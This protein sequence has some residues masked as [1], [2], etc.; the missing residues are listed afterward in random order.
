M[1]T[2]SNQK[3][4]FTSFSCSV[5]LDRS[6]YMLWES[7]VLRMI[8]GDKMYGYISGTSKCPGEFI[9]EEGKQKENSAYEEWVA[10]DQKLL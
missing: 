7:L 4:A 5:K 10:N 8:K 2:I 1:E 6:N 3:N 9:T